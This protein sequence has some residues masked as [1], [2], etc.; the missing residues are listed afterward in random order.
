MIGCE[1]RKGLP[2]VLVIIP[3]RTNATGLWPR[4]RP[5]ALALSIERDEIVLSFIL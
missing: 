5:T 4:T 3:L 1:F 2:L